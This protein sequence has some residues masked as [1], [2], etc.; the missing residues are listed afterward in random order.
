MNSPQNTN[1]RINRQELQNLIWQLAR[2]KSHSKR[3][4]MGQESTC[5]HIFPSPRGLYHLR[6]FIIHVSIAEYLSIKKHLEKRE[7]KSLKECTSPNNSLLPRK[8]TAL[9]S[10]F[11]CLKFLVWFVGEIITTLASNSS[12][13]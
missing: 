9:T 10:S 2:A 3:V 4:S 5:P 13:N 7:Q 12:A 1:H 8:P 6:W 11:R